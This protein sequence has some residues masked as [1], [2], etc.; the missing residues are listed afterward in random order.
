M[1][2]LVT[3]ETAHLVGVIFRVLNCLG[4]YE[5]FGGPFASAPW[6]GSALPPAEQSSHAGVGQFA[7]LRLSVSSR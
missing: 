7:S 1:R 2:G 3:A 4:A 6:A 5:C